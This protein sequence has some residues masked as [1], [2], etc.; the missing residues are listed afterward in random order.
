MNELNTKCASNCVQVSLDNKS[1]NKQRF[2][3]EKKSS[4]GCLK[5]CSTV[6]EDKH[7]TRSTFVIELSR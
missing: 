5:R 3:S 2:S 7:I 1:L 6:C 4:A